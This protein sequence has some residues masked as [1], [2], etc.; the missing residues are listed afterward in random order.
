MSNILD[1]LAW[2]G[3]LTLIQDPFNSID[4]LILSCLSYVD[5][6]GVVPGKG[7]GRITIENAAEKYFSIHSEEEIA[8]DKSFISFGPA[9]FRLLASSERFKGAYLQNFVDDTDISRQMQFAAVEIDTSDGY[10]F[11]SYRGT[12][13]TVVGWK[14]DFN[15]SFMTVPAED[16]AANYLQKVMKGRLDKIRIGGHS[17]GGHLAIYASVAAPS[18]LSDRIE[19]IYN[20]DGPGFNHE[21]ME[22]EN[23]RHIQPKIIKI[24]PQTSIIGRLLE[25][26][27]EPSVVKSNELGIMQ[28]DPL[29]WQLEGKSFELCDST[30]MISDLFDE[31]MSNWLAE[32][33]F[34]DRKVFV[35]ELFSVF[36]ASGCEYLSTLTKIGVKGT[37]AMIERMHHIRNDSGAKV[38]TLVKMFFIN[39]N[40]LKDSVVKERIE[41]GKEKLVLAA[42]LKK[43]N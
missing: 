17:K 3:D 8:Q 40:V 26:T 31:T 20:F 21:A 10:S 37:R 11:I 25:N 38:R 24:I 9:M 27:T 35:D 22:T 29:S 28:H 1:Y 7:G 14:E 5:F 30:D 2:R 42:N 12:D 23:F 16:E 13:D 19:T 33:S 4:A 43:Q 6:T 34:E 32:M 41:E 39:L 15:L 36:E 18:G